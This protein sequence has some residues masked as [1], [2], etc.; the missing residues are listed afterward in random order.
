MLLPIDDRVFYCC[1]HGRRWNPVSPREGFKCKCC[2]EELW[3]PNRSYRRPRMKTCGACS[4][5]VIGNMPPDEIFSIQV[6]K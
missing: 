4:L 3:L 6:D 2:G 5:P 1:P